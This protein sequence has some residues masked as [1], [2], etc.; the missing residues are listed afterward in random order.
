MYTSRDILA[1]RRLA[2]CS[3]NG[4]IRAPLFLPLALL[5]FVVSWRTA[6]RPTATDLSPITQCR[7]EKRRRRAEHLL[8][9]HITAPNLRPPP[10]PPPQ[11]C[12]Q[13]WRRRE[14]RDITSLR[15]LRWVRQRSASSHWQCAKPHCSHCPSPKP[16]AISRQIMRTRRTPDTYRTQQLTTFKSASAQC[17]RCRV[18]PSYEFGRGGETLL[19]RSSIHPYTP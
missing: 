9:C 1:L 13:R 6:D 18:V 5:L 3:N 15:R 2:S 7:R 14:R 17:R 10:P 12:P 11:G 4:N 8:K 16:Q 19:F